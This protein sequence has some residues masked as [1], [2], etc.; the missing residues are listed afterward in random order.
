MYT[1][2][3]MYMREN[4]GIKAEI[5]NAG[6]EATDALLVKLE[7]YSGKILYIDKQR[8]EDDRGYGYQFGA[9]YLI[10]APSAY[11]F[12][13][14]KYEKILSS[15]YEK[16]VV[17]NGQSV[18]IRFAPI[19]NDPDS[20]IGTKADAYKECRL[21]MKGKVIEDSMC[22]SMMLDFKAKSAYGA[23]LYDWE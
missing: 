7:N 5:I 8:D 4:S 11:S 21:E 19:Y 15:D 20:R 16:I 12:D 13:G 1:A 14:G 3:V 9:S 2:G 18:F 17:K 23:A 6:E 22:G 10:L